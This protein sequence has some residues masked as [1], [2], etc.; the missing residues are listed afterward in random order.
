M[1]WRLRQNKKIALRFV[2]RYLL[3]LSPLHIWPADAAFSLVFFPA[4][5]SICAIQNFLSLLI[6]V[7]S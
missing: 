4:S 7:D 3:T 2:I 1:S 5:L 6:N